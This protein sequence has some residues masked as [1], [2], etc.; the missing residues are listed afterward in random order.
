[1][2]ECLRLDRVSAGYR[3]TVVLHQM[4]FSV[5]A[6][7]TVAVLGRNGAGKTTL[8]TTIAG[9]NTFHAGEIYFTATPI[10]TWPIWRR[11]RAGVGLVP[12][13]REIFSTL[14]VEENLLVSARGNTWTIQ[15]VYELFPRLAERRCNGGNELSGG[16][17]QMLAI[18]RALMGSPSLLLLDEPLEGLAPIMVETILQ[19]LMRLREETALTVLL[20]EQRARL[21]LEL[22]SRALVLVSGRIAYDG[23][24]AALKVDAALL[25]RLIGVSR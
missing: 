20:V 13:E 10:G 17:Q 1:M 2:A 8:L 16:E 14:S 6:G 5:A 22:A 18:G 9:F 23:P 7:E 24:S 11:A 25:G 21:A 3:Q 4:S 15:R 19:A 12:Q